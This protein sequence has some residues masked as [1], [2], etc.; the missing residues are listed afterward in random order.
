MIHFVRLP[1][2]LA[3]VVAGAGDAQVPVCLAGSAQLLA[4]AVHTVDSNGVAMAGRS[5]GA[6]TTGG[7]SAMTGAPAGASIGVSRTPG[8]ALSTLSRVE[9]AGGVRR[10]PQ[11]G[12]Y[13]AIVGTVLPQAGQ[14]RI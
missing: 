3:A 10:I 4:L 11:R 14:V 12:Q 2:G 6:G 1:R 5:A 8:R 7:V 9:T 13:L